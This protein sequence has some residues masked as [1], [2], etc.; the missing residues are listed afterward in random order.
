MRAHGALLT[1]AL[2]LLPACGDREREPAPEPPAA[3]A[4]APAAAPDPEGPPHARWDIVRALR[5]SKQ[6]RIEPSDGSGRAWL[7]SSDPEK[8]Q[9]GSPGRFEILFEVGPHGI[10]E[11][12]GIFL[13]V[14]PFWDWSTP[15]TATPEL[16]GYTEVSTEAPGVVLEAQTLDQQLLG[17]AVTGRGLEAGERVRIV[18]G[19][20]FMG[21]TADRYAERFSRFWIAVDGDGDGVRKV[22]ADSPGIEVL[23][24]P[25]ARLLVTLPSVARPGETVRLSVAILDAVGSRGVEL[26]GEVRLE[27]GEGVLELPA[28]VVLEPEHRGVRVVEA[29]VLATGEARVRATGPGG[30]AGESNPLVATSDGPRVL[31]GDLHGHT[32]WSDGTGVPEDYFLY[33]RDVALLDVVA[34]TDHD[35]W[36]MLRLDEQ[37]ERWQGI[38]E[39]TR[40]FHEPGRFV[41]ILGYEWTSW[42][43]GHRHVLYFQDEGPLHSSIAP[44][45]ESPTQ[46]WEALEGESALTFA[47][48][49]AGGPVPVN[50][51]IPPDPRFEPVTEIVS[52]HGSSEAMDSPLLIYSP[53]PGNFVRDVLDRGI[54]LGFVGSGDSHDGHPGLAHIAAPTGGV[55]AIL[56]EERTRDGVLRAL[57]SRRVYATS[58]PR[59]LL[60]TALGAHPMGSVLRLE[61]RESTSEELFVRAVGTAPVV[62]VDLV[63]SGEVVDQ[64]LSE[65]RLEMVLQRTVSELRA[66][67]YVYVRVVQED[68]AV[69]WSSPIFVE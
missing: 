16:P 25:P 68:G 17:I 60:R 3:E 40:R 50:W 43:H 62:R 61:G 51:D 59:I 69:A 38:Q 67:E 12:G 57:R 14:S 1:L 66:G 2:A 13:Q 54:R 9:A 6:Q 46:L 30:L 35:H 10:A 5:E 63:R 49:S 52:V 58:G 4:E 32:S 37:P 31:W 11:G 19:A 29:R 53:V 36:G 42:I 56:S 22:L 44:E 64:A 15:Q 45:T 28:R 7:E 20:G 8:P 39:V 47:H 27:G 65:G 48:H 55:V 41:T 23:P 33:A 34:L 24:G 18:Y 21:A 26:A